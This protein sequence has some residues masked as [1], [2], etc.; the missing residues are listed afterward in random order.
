MKERKLGERLS[1]MRV[2]K[3]NLFGTWTFRKLFIN[4]LLTYFVLEY[5]Y[6]LIEF[7]YYV[8]IGIL[9]PLHHPTN[10]V[11]VSALVFRVL[12]P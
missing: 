2:R 12:G 9:V 3:E 6:S 4:R 10:V 11:R 8:V 1:D 7:H 5:G